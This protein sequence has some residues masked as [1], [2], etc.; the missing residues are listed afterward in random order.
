MRQSRGDGEEPSCS[1][2]QP[3]RKPAGQQRLGE[4]LRPAAACTRTGVL[5]CAVLL[6]TATLPEVWTAGTGLEQAHSK[7][8]RRLRRD[9]ASSGRTLADSSS[10]GMPRGW[11]RRSVDVRA[12]A[13]VVLVAYACLFSLHSWRYTL[14]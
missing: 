13:P 5:A 12:C 10:G 9:H 4:Q 7:L 2:S 3:G 8:H 6:L 14:Q 11:Y 1:T